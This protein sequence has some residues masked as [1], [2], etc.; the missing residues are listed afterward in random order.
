MSRPF[1]I[2]ADA[3]VEE[4]VAVWEYVEPEFYDRRPIEVQLPNLPVY[5]GVNAFWLVDGKASHR[6]SGKGMNVSLTP[7]SMERAQAKPFSIGSQ[8]IEDVPARLRDMAN[9]QLD[10]QVLFPTTFNRP[11]TE[12]VRLETA[13]QKAWNRWAATAARPSRG[14]LKPVALMP[15]QE[16]EQAIA[17]ARWAKDNGA[18]GLAV[19]PMMG[20]RLLDD[21]AFEPF[22]AAVNELDLP[23][24]IH[25]GWYIDGLTQLFDTQ[26][27]NR[28]FGIAMP[29]MIA[30]GCFLR[31]SVFDRYPNLRVGIFEAGCTWAPYFIERMDRCFNIDTNH[32]WWAPKRRPSEYI[33]EQRICF[34][35]EPD[36]H[37][38]APT[39]AEIGEGCFMLSS[40][41]PHAELRDSAVFEVEARTDLTAEQK[42][43]IYSENALRFFGP[44]IAEVEQ[45]AQEVGIRG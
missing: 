26:F 30:M 29:S 4:P 28:T 2:D 34:T 8:T 18:A 36:E 33:A 20:G 40:D 10:V 19:Y 25:V 13:L 38:L 39:I 11:L 32:G 14:R 15:L 22:Y 17:E 1:V 31:T 6:M 16:P 44:Q 24:C 42:R 7:V 45:V 43:K 21:P 23:I 5:R 9:L 3:H 41:M 35:F 27:M 37:L 12:D